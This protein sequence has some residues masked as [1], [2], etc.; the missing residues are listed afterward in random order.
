MFSSRVPRDLTPN[1]LAHRVAAFRASAREPLD[2]TVTN[3]TTVGLEFPADML[4]SLSEPAA[5]TYRPEPFGL[6]S[7]R[8]AVALDYC[9]RGTP[10]APERIVLT[11]STSEAYSVL[12]KLLC[13]PGDR[14]L[15]PTPSYPLF[16]H[17]ARLDAIEADPYR[18]EYHGRWMLN[19]ASLESAWSDRTRAV[20]AVSPNN[21][22]GS[23]LSADEQALL[24]AHCAGRNAALIVDEVF[25]DYLMVPGSVAPWVRGSDALMFRLGGL[26]KSIGL[27]QV[28]LGWFVVDGPDALATD[29]L[30]R[31]EIICDTYLS[32]STPVQVAAGDLL[33]KGVIVRAAILDRVRRNHSALAE[34]TARHPSTE[35]LRA[36]GGWSAVLRIPSPN[37]EEQVVLELLEEDGVLVHPGYFFDFAH[38]SFVV[39]SLLPTPQ[40]FDEGVRRLLARVDG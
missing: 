38:E 26:S 18:L 19:G 34:M 9:R 20:L 2:L 6:A 22:T 3:P 23:L 5:L 16:D 7:A 33:E 39:V 21:P 13:D 37:G 11:A 4:A 8:E 36:D 31:L 17:L 25:A 24:T 15:V 29:A 30:E 1:R 10:V 14:V 32:V 27:P 35:L 28:K 40:V 12:F